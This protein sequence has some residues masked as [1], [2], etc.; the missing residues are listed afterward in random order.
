MY[1][2]LPVACTRTVTCLQPFVHCLRDLLQ[3][4]PE[5]CLGTCLYS[6]VPFGRAASDGNYINYIE[7]FKNSVCTVKL[8]SYIVSIL[9]F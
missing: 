9:G 8:Y 7:K 5:I 1:S 3:L 6:Y 2:T 4:C